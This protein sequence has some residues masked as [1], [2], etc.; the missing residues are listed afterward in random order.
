L[1]I[2][3]E[4][5][6]VVV[7]AQVDQAIRDLDRV[8]KAGRRA[9]SG[10][11]AG[12]TKA[13]R[14]GKG[15][16]AASMLVRTAATGMA[17]AL[18]GKVIMAAAD[19]N[20]ELSKSGV[21]FGPQADRVV[22][23]ADK[24]AKKFGVN[25]TEF[26]QAAGGLGL[27]AKA[28]GQS[29]REAAKL[30]I[31]F[32]KLAADAASFY[33]VPMKDALADIKS[34]LVGESEP[35]RKYGVLLSENAVKQEAYRKGIAK[36]GAEL[37]EG[38]K[39]QARSILIMK[40]MKDA[41]GDLARTQGS[42][43]NR[44]RELKGRVMNYAAELGT[45]ALPATADFLEFLIDKGIP[46]AQD[47]GKAFSEDVLP[48]LKGLVGIGGQVLGFLNGLPGPLKSNGV[49]AALMA[50]GVY[51]INNAIGSSKVSAWVGD[52]RNSETRLDA[53]SR[54]SRA[55]GNG[56]RT[57]AGGAGFLMLS[58]SM[59]KVDD[60]TRTFQRT[61]G[62]ALAGLSVGGP[63]G[64]AV[65]ALAGFGSAVLQ[66]GKKAAKGFDLA[67]ASGR[68]YADTLGVLTGR[69]SANTRAFVV[70]DLTKNYDAAVRAAA[71]LGI[72][73][74]M[75]ARDLMGSE[76]AHAKVNQK[77]REGI[78]AGK[79]MTYENGG[80]ARAADVLRAALG[81]QNTET[82]NGVEK[83]KGLRAQMREQ[84]KEAA[85]GA[86]R[87]R[88]LAGALKG[89]PTEVV[90]DIIQDGGAQSLT[91]IEKLIDKYHR[92]PPQVRTL[93]K[94][95]GVTVTDREMRTLINHGK[96]LDQMRPKL[97][98]GAETDAARTKVS[99]L[100]TDIRN[101][102]SGNF[103]AL[104]QTRTVG[105]K[106]PGSAMGETVPGARR[107]YRDSVLRLLAPGEE[108][109]PNDRGQAD[110]HR[111]LLKAIARDRVPGMKAGGTVGASRALGV[112]TRDLLAAFREGLAPATKLLARLEKVTRKNASGA[113]EKRAL[114]YLER[115]TKR[116]TA[117]ETS[118]ATVQRRLEAAVANRDSL[119]QA[120]ADFRQNVTQ[121]ISAQANVL[122]SGN[123]A[124][125][126]G[127]SLAVQVAKAREFA[128]NLQR[129]RAAGFSSAII[130]QVA[131]AG[132]EA[133]AEVAKALAAAGTGDVSSINSSFAQINAIAASTGATLS[134][135][136]Y[137]S[138]ISAAQGVIA[139]LNQQKAKIEA[140]LTLIA[141]GMVKALRRAL[142]IHSPSVVF[143]R[144][145]NYVGQGAILGLRDQGKAVQR[146]SRK[147]ASQAI[148]GFAQ[149]SGPGM[150][151][152]GL[153]GGARG[154]TPAAMAGRGGNAL[155]L[156]FK[157]YNPV[158]EPQS[159]TTNKGLDRVAALGLV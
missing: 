155:H 34:G 121:G 14:G 108:V 55:L 99:T 21:V 111:G 58:K 8:D 85:A 26:L 138:G 146:E 106:A 134:N 110:R 82:E 147:L 152:W 23:A 157:T 33:N 144:Q 18:V 53:V 127:T 43:S 40:G 71:A 45:K 59:G 51:K 159:R 54:A 38:Q 105:P 60:D 80:Q 17:G 2:R 92:T 156:E 41:H 48:T 5:L 9:G 32:G 62:G 67:E 44:L 66:N 1:S 125:A 3:A 100:V 49:M 151:S 132:I 149:G 4:D 70:Q 16:S 131:A 128:A 97:R 37:T 75:L 25:K 86:A 47:F 83:S 103:T 13:R 142:G 116:V 15:F 27:V 104:I 52:L 94:A 20:E 81:R 46:A 117:L 120:K 65:G 12:G 74:D 130:Q 136:M 31:G 123:S 118:R 112:S 140:T 87:A 102:L 109:V 22:K 57:L 143:R 35:M 63:I 36:Q 95:L 77:V 88:E 24:M 129:M 30:S 119:I 139:G 126:I 68:A 10:V 61:M 141:K 148:H 6:E 79:M 154:L 28:S 89:V 122:N 84:R 72:S 135:Q 7:R 107:P 90:T 114:A 29:Q 96:T 93:V 158:S 101:L 73:T 91:N 76:K 50:V 145:M 39:V 78:L 98:V 69:M 56:I 133:G 64:A 11:E 19:L 113:A 42:V 137:D 124:A 150:S 153:S 115:T